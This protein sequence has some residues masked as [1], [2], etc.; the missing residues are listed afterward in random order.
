MPKSKIEG[1][2]FLKNAKILLRE[3]NEVEMP[4][5]RDMLTTTA[6]RKRC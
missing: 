3:L 4:E 6:T 2:V 5:P 1:S